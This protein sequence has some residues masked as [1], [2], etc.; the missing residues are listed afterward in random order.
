M[1]TRITDSAANLARMPI[2]ARSL[3]LIV[4]AIAC[5]ALPAAAM[6]NLAPEQVSTGPAGGNGSAHVFQGN[7]SAD[8][9]CVEFE[10]AEALTSEDPNSRS[11]YYERCGT[12]TRLLTIGPASGAGTAPSPF[13][14]FN[15]MAAN[16]C[17][18]FGTNEQLADEDGD[19]RIDLYKRCGSNLDLI[20]IGENG[21]GNGA[22]DVNQGNI[23]ED[24]VC[25][26][27]TAHEKLTTDDG[28][29]IPDWFERCGTTLK[30]ITKGDP[31]LG[32]DPSG[33]A[34]LE[35]MSADGSCVLFQTGEKLLD[36][37]TD[38]NL[39]LYTRCGSVTKKVSPGN[40]AFDATSDGFSADGSC[41]V[42]ETDE[43][44]AS[45]D[46][47][48]NGDG[49]KVC[50]STVT[51]ITTGP[52]G[53]N[54]AQDTRP[55]EVSR[56]LRCVTF[57]SNE[58]LTSDDHDTSFDLYERCGDDLERVS[59]GGAGGNAEIDADG[60][61][62]SADGRCA[63]FSTEEHI[64]DSDAD[65]SPDIFKRC[66]ST[67]EQVSQGPA[68]GNSGANPD[69]RDVSFDGER[70]VFQTEEQL[71]ADD[72]DT[73]TDIYERSNG[74]TTRITPPDTSVDHYGSNFS[75]MSVDGT[76][77][78]FSRRDS[79]AASDT[80]EFFDLYSITVDPTASLR[81]AT[82]LTQTGATLNGFTSGGEYHFEYGPTD[83]YGTSTPAQTATGM[84]AVSAP[85]SGLTAATT[86]HYRLVVTSS[87]G[88]TETQDGT[89]TTPAVPSDSGNSGNNGNNGG[90]NDQGQG[91][92]QGQNP[93]PPPPPVI[94][95]FS[96]VRI[97]GATVKIRKG[98]AQIKVS[99][100]ASAQ[101]SCAGT[102]VLKAKG[103]RIGRKSFAIAAGTSK[104][105]RVRISKKAGKRIKATATATAHDS[106]DVDV[107][108]TAKL[109]LRR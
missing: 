80:D 49:Y 59:K 33:F 78:L 54:A 20:S 47:D 71:V 8:G 63:L 76:R 67:T 84:G 86:Y 85:I 62:L 64:T 89:F 108:T 96:G 6:A 56:D 24:G 51:H 31:G 91:Q 9:Q 44:L 102:L 58:A 29:T 105:V 7:L 10:T 36:E 109:K 79:L 17:V 42:L 13:H 19:N 27:F 21:T 22:F 103:K 32:D 81:D 99:C 46:T 92:D 2:S 38:S 23:S 3:L 12:T 5:L 94:T 50:G 69:V 15:G 52:G 101:G 106:R 30:R 88:T 1:T 104:K 45:T 40:G 73:F 60:E 18:L 43:Q 82:S 55:D 37:D 65:A 39:D 100:P 16:G 75:G 83:A 72:T 28:D 11:D 57:E 70:V 26:A 66:G 68:G 97:S 4:V 34:N 98:I 87:A 14:S 61:W 90:G 77:I 48:S 41:V 25:V 74:V 93:P 95:E 107:K 53:G 35:G